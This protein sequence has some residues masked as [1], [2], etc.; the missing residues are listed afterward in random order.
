MSEMTPPPSE[1][2]NNFLSEIIN[3]DLAS[4]KIKKL[5]TRFP[6]EPNGFLHVGHAKAISVNFG[7]ANRFGG[8]C[9]LRFD[10][11]NPETEEQIYIDSI[12]ADIQWLGFD[13]GTNLFYTSSY[14][15]KL[16]DYA[17][18][19]IKEGKAFVC[20]Q[21]VDEIRATR[22]TLTESGTPSPDR[23]RPI[24]E[25]VSLFE[26]MRHG[27]FKDGEFTVR[28]KID[29]GNANMKMRD[30]LLYRI[31]HAEHPK[32]GR[33][34][35]IYPMY[36]FAH[37]LSD[38]IE[39]ITHSICTLEFEN[40]RELYD[41]ILAACKVDNI[42]RQYEMARLQMTY[43][44]TSKRKLKALVDDGHVDGWDDPRMPTIA[45]LRRRGVP[46]EAIRNFC[47][48]IGVT[49]ANTTLDM[50]RFDFHLRQTLNHLS[51]R[52]M[53]VIDP[54]K[55]VLTNFPK[56]K[57]VEWLDASYW[58]HDIPKE[59]GRKVPFSQE[60][61]IERSDFAE[62][63]PK[64]F[65]RLR[66]GG[67]VRLRYGYFIKCEKVIKN[68]AGEVTALHC[69]YDV[70]TIG[71]KAPDGRKVKGTIHWV[72]ASES[73]SAEFRRYNNL[74]E[75]ENVGAR[76]GNYEDD[77]ASESVQTFHGRIEPSVA[78]DNAETRYQFERNGYFC[79]DHKALPDTLVFNEIIGLRDSWAK[80]TRKNE[81]SNV[82]TG[83]VQKP[84][85]KK[86]EKAPRPTKRTPAQLRDLKRQETP[87]LQ[88]DFLRYQAET[89][90][91]EH[92]ADIITG[93]ETL[94]SLFVGALKTATNPKVLSKWFTNVL[95][96]L[97]ESLASPPAVNGDVLAD[98]IDLIESKTISSTSGKEV[99]VVLLT[100][101]GRASEV[102]DT[103]NLAQVSDEASLLAVLADILEANPGKVAAVEAGRTQLAGFF[104]GQ[105]MRVMPNANPQMVQQLV[106]SRFKL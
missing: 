67:E 41:W 10:D 38:S 98:V 79:R 3:S 88:H 42:S 51:P 12:Q 29:M 21:S 65:Y 5:V 58:P 64:G 7:L 104:I 91:T 57:E 48:D 11:T 76:T 40:N 15:E 50:S 101:G 80:A 17:V 69:T 20:S 90:L 86:T 97:L 84:T 6:P 22:G 52:V 56:D 44:I 28:A 32:T 37:C 63:P 26:Q 71:G 61:F 16:Y 105:V 62:S 77:L 100:Q 78:Q 54:L 2:R 83:A 18:V 31:R 35:C 13:W 102:V 96:S 95:P 92:D 75:T 1:T 94:N 27:D 68:E 66:P 34:W 85:V 8:Q 45:G 33:T 9:H 89:G 25:S 4:G 103:L 53:A 39:G 43:I 87:T 47:E 70:D 72:S 81:A 49:K 55:V 36:D 30:P 93:S 24:A 19:L 99:A 106:H 14:F 60:L 23:N 82:K 74:F 59:G 73:I 46:P